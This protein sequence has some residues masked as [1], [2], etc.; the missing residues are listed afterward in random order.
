MGALMS[1]GR[2]KLKTAIIQA[3]VN[4]RLKVA[5]EEAA[6]MDHRSLTNWIEVLIHNRCKELNIDP[7]TPSSQ[8]TR[9]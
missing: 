4:P 2:P 9:A 8:E 3:R 7:E 6:K 5:A 1:F